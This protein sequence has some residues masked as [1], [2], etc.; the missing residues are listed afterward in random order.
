M[1]NTRIETLAEL[2]KVAADEAAEA[3]EASPQPKDLAKR[4]SNAAEIHIGARELGIGAAAHEEASCELADMLKEMRKRYDEAAKHGL[5]I[6][7]KV[8]AYRMAINN[9]LAQYDAAFDRLAKKKTQLE[10][11]VAAVKQLGAALENPHIQK[12]LWGDK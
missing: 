6:L 8:R 11:C 3:I 10:E 5:G 12:L 2:A 7:E 1:S 9:E 4:L